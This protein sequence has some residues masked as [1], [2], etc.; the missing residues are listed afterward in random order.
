MPTII[1]V[2]SRRFT[3]YSKPRLNT[4]SVFAIDAVVGSVVTDKDKGDEE[5]AVEE[6]EFSTGCTKRWTR[7]S[8]YEWNIESISEFVDEYMG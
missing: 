3:I 6:E 4:S 7:S 1:S 5:E 2:C 8:I